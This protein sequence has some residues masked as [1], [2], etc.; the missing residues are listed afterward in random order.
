MAES[1]SAEERVALFLR[2]VNLFLETLADDRSR[3][4][5]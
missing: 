4:E 5:R 3:F 1:F 2:G